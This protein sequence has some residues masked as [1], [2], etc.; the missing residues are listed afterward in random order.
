MPIVKMSVFV[1]H[2]MNERIRLPAQEWL[3]YDPERGNLHGYT[4][5]QMRE[6]A[7]LIVKECIDTVFDC[8]VE[9]CTRPQIVSEIKEHFG[10]KE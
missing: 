7:E 8:G 2:G 3:G 5:E 9:Y 10:V 4:F 6:F 1:E